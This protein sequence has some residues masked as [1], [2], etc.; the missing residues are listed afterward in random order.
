M[1]NGALVDVDRGD[2]GVG[3]ADRLQVDGFARIRLLLIGG[4]FAGD[5]GQRQTRLRLRRQR[6]EEGRGQVV[7]LLL[8]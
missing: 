8:K 7:T 4:A 1:L 6:Q 2:D 5:G 3:D